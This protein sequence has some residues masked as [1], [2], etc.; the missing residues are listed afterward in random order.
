MDVVVQSMYV[1]MHLYVFYLK[2]YES[3]NQRY[4]FAGHKVTTTSIATPATIYIEYSRYVRMY[5]Y[6]LY[7]CMHLFIYVCMYE[8]V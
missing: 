5:S 4:W 1:C 3:N 6:M 7:V 8:C 2:I